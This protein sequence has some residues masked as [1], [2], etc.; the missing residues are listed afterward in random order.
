[1]HSISLYLSI[2][3]CMLINGGFIIYRQYK[4]HASQIISPNIKSKRGI[5][6]MCGGYNDEW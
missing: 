2:F 4:F 3:V 5:E 6:W 1:M